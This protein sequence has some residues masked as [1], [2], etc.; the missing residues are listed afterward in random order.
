MAK[1]FSVDLSAWQKT[2]LFLFIFGV[3]SVYAHSE[4]PPSQNKLPGLL[5]FAQE[6]EARKAQEAAHPDKDTD[7]SAPSGIQLPQIRLKMLQQQLTAS[8][9]REQLYRQQL[10]QQQSQ[11]VATQWQR[12]QDIL[13]TSL[14]TVVLE[15]K[16][17]QQQAEQRTLAQTLQTQKNTITNL[18][19]NLQLLTQKTE[20]DNAKAAASRTTSTALTAEQLKQNDKLKQAY[21]AGIAI[22]QDALTIHQDNQAYGQAFDKAAYL[23]GINDAIEGRTLLSPTELHTA[24]IASETSVEK[25]KGEQKNQQAQLA[26]RFLAEWKTQKGVKS[27]P[28]GYVYKINYVGQGAIQPEDF[29]SIVVKEAL[30]D[31]TVVSDMDLQNKSLTLPLADYPPLFQSAIQHLQNHGE[32][33]FVVPPE[34]AYGD[35]GYPPAVPPGASLQYT[36]RIA[37]VQPAPAQSPNK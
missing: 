31:G 29:I 14:H 18:T 15:A 17:A 10:Q 34:L 5:Q 2:P 16:W 21:A 26:K 22:G 32:I 12:A 35:A 20:R 7:W 24:L 8:Q 9:H 11:R 1:P 27:D 36:L 33:T 3:F 13:T 6:Y 23:A 37:D 25:H 4:T 19:N 28:L 30:L